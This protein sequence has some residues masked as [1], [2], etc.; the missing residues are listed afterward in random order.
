VRVFAIHDVQG[1]ISQL[2][3]APTTDS[4]RPVLVTPAGLTMTEIGD[5]PVDAASLESQEGLAEFAANY[6]VNVNNLQRAAAVVR[7]S[8]ERS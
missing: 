4:A 3:T 8:P 5:L 7:R 6:V 1:D 2:V